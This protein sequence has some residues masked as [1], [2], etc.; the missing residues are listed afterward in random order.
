MGYPA[1]MTLLCGVQPAHMRASRR[2]YGADA[3]LLIVAVLNDVQLTTLLKLTRELGMEAL[4]EVVTA[5]E[6]SRALAAG[7]SVIGVNNRNLRNF[8]VDTS[9]T[10]RVLFEAGL[11]GPGSKASGKVLL[12]L[13]GIQNRVDVQGY[14][15][16]GVHGV[17]VGEALM[18]APDPR[19]MIASLRGASGTGTLV[20]ICGLQSGETAAATAMAGADMIGLV[21]AAGSKRL[22]SIEQARKIVEH[23]KSR[24]PVESDHVS[25][26]LTPPWTAEA[27]ETD[28]TT[29][30]GGW[31][32]KLRRASSARP[33]FFGVFA[34]QP[35][36]S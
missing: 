24:F 10:G 27:S 8:T 21:F 23:V 17:L 2:R 9:K 5:E 19:V 29:W 28:A 35:V 18:R 26:A 1:G 15:A 32:D 6:L 20:K 14:R 25:R 30:F 36:R 3:V 22:V 11:S 7:A 13:S 33:L 31:V 16:S 12:A 34:D 4:V